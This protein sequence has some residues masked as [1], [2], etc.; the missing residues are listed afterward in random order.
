[1]GLSDFQALQS[2]IYTAPHR[3]IFFAFDLL[4]LDGQD[5]VNR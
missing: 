5:P 2:A 3:I 1:M 4:H